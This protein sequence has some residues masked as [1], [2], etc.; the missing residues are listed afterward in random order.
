MGNTAKSFTL[1]VVPDRAGTPKRYRIAKSWIYVGLTTF[2]MAFIGVGSATY[3]YTAVVGTAAEARALREENLGLRS[4]LRLVEEKVAHFTT[5]L[6]RVERMD[7]KL[8]MLTQVSDPERNLAIGPVSGGGKDPIDAQS[9]LLA[10]GSAAL[11]V[12][13]DAIATDS[14]IELLHAK[15]ENLA[16]DAR[17]EE[18]SLAELQEYFEDQ[19]TLLA[20][21]PS[22][23]PARGWVT[24]GFGTRA[25]PFTADRS[26]HKGLDVA[27]EAG[28]R[29]K[30]PADGTVVF[31]GT[32]GAY[33]NV[34]VIDHGFG[35]NTR[36]GHLSEIFVKV[37]DKLPRGQ[38]FA[39][40]GNTGRSTGP[41]LHY[42]VRVNGIPQ[43]PRKFILD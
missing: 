6:E 3:H 7:A 15:L 41:H 38:V 27:A 13:L 28:T 9:P 8:R 21:M 4:E 30:A 32:H 43:D 19:K 33:G 20:A 12:G 39:A 22:V 29:V 11:P 35:M 42:E 16:A 23:W 36:Y 25:D 24:S 37:G 10:R 14:D 17:R 2:V 18:A 5:S 34:V 31:A 1:M 26:M 40:I